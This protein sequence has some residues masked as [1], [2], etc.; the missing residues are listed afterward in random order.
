MLE[1]PATWTGVIV[2]SLI[3]IVF[4]LLLIASTVRAHAF[5]DQCDER[6]RIDIENCP[7]GKVFV[8]R[9]ASISLFFV[10][11]SGPCG[12]HYE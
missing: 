6:T 7:P 12:G 5:A 10:S 1:R 2:A 11:W 9:E 8:P 3:P 4:L